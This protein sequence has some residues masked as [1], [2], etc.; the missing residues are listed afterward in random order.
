[1]QGS[2]LSMHAECLLHM[3]TWITPVCLW[4][5]APAGAQRGV[6][7]LSRGLCLRGALWQEPPQ[8]KVHPRNTTIKKTCVLTCARA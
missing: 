3:H 1:M 4:S 7:S 6:S 8:K 2:V 5:H